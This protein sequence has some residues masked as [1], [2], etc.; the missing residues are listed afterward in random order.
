MATTYSGHPSL[1]HLAAPD[2]DA[3]IAAAHGRGAANL[4]S[5]LR[6]WRAPFTPI[7]SGSAPCADLANVSGSIE[8]AIAAFVLNDNATEVKLASDY[9]GVKSSCIGG[10]A[11]CEWSRAVPL[12]PPT[13]G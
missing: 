8:G 6:Q 11:M 5:R 3:V 13:S 1:P 2:Y 12:P 9:L 4:A 10:F 7:A